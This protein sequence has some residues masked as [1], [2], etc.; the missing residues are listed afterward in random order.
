MQQFHTVVGVLG[1]VQGCLRCGQGVARLRLVDD[2]QQLAFPHGFSLANGQGFQHGHACK[3]HTR[4]GFLL[5]YPHIGQ[6]HRFGN[7]C[8][9]LHCDTDCIF[10]S[11]LRLLPTGDKCQ[12]DTHKRN[13]PT[14]RHLTLSIVHF[15]LPYIIILIF[16]YSATKLHYSSGMT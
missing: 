1:L 4:R 14:V 6:A 7:G 9:T 3:A 13:E 15:F 10:G 11:G 2:G 5:H 16:N 12:H 8:H